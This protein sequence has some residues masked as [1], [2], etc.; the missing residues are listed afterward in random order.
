VERPPQES[1]IV[2]AA[3]EFELE[4]FTAELPRPQLSRPGGSSPE[5]RPVPGERLA[6]AAPPPGRPWS[7]KGS[8]VP[9]LQIVTGRT[10]ASR[11]E[12]LEQHEIGEEFPTA[13]ERSPESGS[14][15][16]VAALRPLEEPWW[17]VWIEALLTSRLLQAAVLAAVVLIGCIAFWPRHQPGVALSRLRKHPEQ[18]EGQTVRVRG[19]VGDVFHV[20]A[21]HVF[22]LLQGRD[23]VVVFTPQQP[24]ERHQRIEVSGSVSTGYLDGVPRIAIFVQPSAAQ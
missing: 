2:R 3:S 17:M 13:H 22:Q 9:R 16:A 23:T 24:P 14:P 19:K 10:P 1:F 21:G 11:A 18:F 8:S 5:P 4:P 15:A 12:D 20:G 7:G 6:P